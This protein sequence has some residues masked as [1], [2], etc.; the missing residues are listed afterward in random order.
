MSRDK[1]PFE[2]MVKEQGASADEPNAYMVYEV[3][4]EVVLASTT[5]CERFIKTHVEE[6]DGKTV[7]IVQIK[8][9]VLVEMQVKRTAN[10]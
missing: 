6:F 7:R 9:E 8:K 5:D 2:I 1:K 4:D 10:L 3:P